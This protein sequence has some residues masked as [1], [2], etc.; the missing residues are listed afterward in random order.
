VKEKFISLYIDIAKRIAELSHASRL[1]VGAVIV[2]DH[3]ILSYGYN[4]TPA[5]FDNCC[6]IV[7][8]EQHTVTKPE[9]IHAEMNA[10]MKVARSSD[11]CAGAILFQTHAPCVDCAKHICQS[12]ISQV[13]YNDAYRSTAGLELLQ[14]AG[15]E[16]IKV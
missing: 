1:K 13:Y 7:I 4:G 14:K 3:R 5:G 15:I 11:S 6:E 16:T 12:G 9:V 2:K 10:L 8:D